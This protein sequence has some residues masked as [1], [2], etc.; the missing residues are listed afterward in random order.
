ML[1]NSPVVACQ[2]ICKLLPSKVQK[3][4]SPFIYKDLSGTDCGK[5]PETTTFVLN[6]S[7]SKKS[8]S[9][10]LMHIA[11][12]TCSRGPHA[13]VLR[14]REGMQV[15]DKWSLSVWRVWFC[16]VSPALRVE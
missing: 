4:L 6:Q 12:W 13:M 10:T 1:G 5:F 8:P 16:S 15:Q 2:G 3:V 9:K 7:Q 11:E 14:V